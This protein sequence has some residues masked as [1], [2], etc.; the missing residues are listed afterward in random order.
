MTD[1]TPPLTVVPAGVPVN[2]AVTVTGT[3][4]FTYQ[5]IQDST[6]VPAVT[7]SNYS[8]NALAG[9]NAYGVTISNA[10]GSIVS[11]TGVVLGLTNTPPVIG[12]NGNGT[13]WTLNEGSVTM[14]TITNDVLTLT[15]GVTS[16]ATSAFYNTPQY[17]GGF[18]ASF[19]YTAG[20]ARGADGITFCM[21][22]DPLGTNAVGGG[23]GALG[24]YGITNS[25]AF[26]MNLYTGSPGGTG[27]QFGAEGSAPPTANPTAP[28][29]SAAPV[30]LSSG[31]PIYVQLYYSQGVLN[32]WLVD[33]T[34]ESVFVTNYDCDLPALVAGP[35]AYVGFSWRRWL[36]QLHPDRVQL[37][38]FVHDASHS[39][40]WRVAQRGA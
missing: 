15:A 23:G 13:D 17:I 1:L 12:L 2:Y 31:D 3:E 39:L 8:F 16:E 7:G 32:V 6:V 25:A 29:S 37:R 34:A 21:E 11:A 33:A 22:N 4:P 40:L 30:Y 28:Y 24:Y 20:G 36:G 27:I 19:T 18:I 38:V 14:P 26:E 35:S 9:S 5:W 10:D